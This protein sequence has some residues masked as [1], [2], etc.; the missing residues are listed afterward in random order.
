MTFEEHGYMHIKNVLSKDVCDIA[1][2][3]ALFER[4]NDVSGKYK[5]PATG[6]VPYTHSVAYDCLMESILLFLKPTVEKYSG[7]KLIP[8]RSYY[9]IYKPNDVLNFHY[10][11]PMCE[12]S[13]T[14][15][16]GYKYY[17]V[18]KSYKWPIFI[19]NVPL[20]TEPGDAILYRGCE[21]EHGRKSLEVGK[22][23]Y[24]V[25]VF[26]HYVDA[27]GPYAEEYKFDK[28]PNIGI[29]KVGLL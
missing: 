3:Y 19:D 21:K 2:Q 23:S 14:V 17:D 18:D 8:T 5:D 24:H 15:T 4:M 10:D 29:K 26:L 12:I 16:L 11:N 7:L 20:T 27:N 6:H 13:M 9:R 22:N 1:T 25:Q 28:R